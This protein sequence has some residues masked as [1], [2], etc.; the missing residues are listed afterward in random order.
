[1]NFKNADIYF[2]RMSSSL[3]LFY[4]LSQANIWLDPLNN[5]L[6]VLGYRLFIIL[7]PLCFLY[8]KHKSSFIA[9]VIAETGLMFWL[10]HQTLMGTL[11]F[12]IGISIIGYMLK[13]YSSFSTRGAAGNKIA[14]NLGGI[15][16]GLLL[17]FSQNI[18][19][20]LIGCFTILLSSTLSF[21][22]Y[23]K[24]ENIANFT[25]PASHFN[26]KNL[27][28]L[29]G[30]A[31]ALTGFVI[32]VKLIS[33]VSILPQCLIQHHQG[34]MPYWFGYIIIFNSFLVVCLQM[35]IMNKIKKLTTFTAL[36]PLLIGMI[37]IALSGV[38][39][40]SSV[41]G[42]LIWT[43]ALSLVE[44]TVSYLDK[45][46]QDDDCLLIKETAVGI[47]C[48][49]TVFCV[50]YFPAEHGAFLI[51]TVSILLLL[52]PFIIFSGILKNTW[53]SLQMNS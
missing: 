51:G 53:R 5:T 33:I 28:T 35:P 13:Y 45:L 47:G 25:T 23:F 38:I 2:S 8:F 40:I 44:C 41:L 50:R 39:G 21:F 15:F 22:N 34:Q 11:L 6:L 16:S 19:F 31:W 14:L 26:L 30:I 37:I 24:R 4:L 49:A 43:M 3:C 9:F 10:A 18:H 12:S 42:A 1:M 17:S 7:T 48:A 52:F 36:I 46:S 20:M 29:K 27:F 32:G